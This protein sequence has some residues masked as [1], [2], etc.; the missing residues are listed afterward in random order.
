MEGGLKEEREVQIAETTSRFSQIG[1]TGEEFG[2]RVSQVT[3]MD[4]LT[5]AVQETMGPKLLER[6]G[7][8]E[9]QAIGSVRRRPGRPA[10]S[11][12]AFIRP[13]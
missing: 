7:W 3:L 12:Q 9:G 11:Q 2:R 5:P 10:D 6:M 1:S 13:G 8:K 4:L